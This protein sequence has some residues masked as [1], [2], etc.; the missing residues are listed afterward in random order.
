MHE[1][2]VQRAVAKNAEESEVAG[3]SRDMY[4]KAKAA[5]DKLALSGKLLPKDWKLENAPKL[6][7]AIESILTKAHR[8]L[9]CLTACHV[10]GCALMKEN[11]PVGE[12]LFINAGLL[13]NSLP[14]SGVPPLKMTSQILCGQKTAKNAWKGRLVLADELLGSLGYSGVTTAYLTESSRGQ[15]LVWS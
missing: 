2:P 12:T 9:A 10:M 14:S 4:A 7:S 1:R 13:P 8:P 5:L 15:L 3:V 6:P 11:I